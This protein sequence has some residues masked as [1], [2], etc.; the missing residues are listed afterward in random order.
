MDSSQRIILPPIWR[1]MRSSVE[2]TLIDVWRQVLVENATVVE[3]DGN[4]YPVR[5]SPR[6]SL[7]QV[8]FVFDGNEIRGLEQNPD[9]KIAV[10]ANGTVGEEGDAVPQRGSVCGERR[11]WEGDVLWWACRRKSLMHQNTP[12]KGLIIRNASHHT[13]P[14]LNFLRLGQGRYSHA[15]RIIPR[16]GSRCESSEDQATLGHTAHHRGV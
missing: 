14:K 3:L 1:A 15:R 2:E 13:P 12:R 7:R 16:V 5:R 10:G 9:T 4:R 11:G 6:R 8:D